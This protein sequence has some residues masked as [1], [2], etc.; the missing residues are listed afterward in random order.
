[1]NDDMRI[2]GERQRALALARAR[3]ARWVFVCVLMAA[4]ALGGC[5]KEEAAEEMDEG[6]VKLFRMTAIMAVAC[7]R[8]KQGIAAK[9][10]RCIGMR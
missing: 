9:Q 4:L 10:T 7:A 8:I 1:M 5:K 3:P 6:L 2:D